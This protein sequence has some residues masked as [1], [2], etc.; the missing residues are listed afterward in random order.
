MRVQFKQWECWLKVGYYSQGRVA[1]VL[2][3]DEGPVATATVNVTNEP[4]ADDEVCIK[5]YSENE[6]MVAAL[7]EAGVVEAPHREVATGFVK[8]PVCRLTEAARIFVEG[9]R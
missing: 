7:V 4:L 8:V 9:R 6:G 5:D 1:L 2:G 3:S